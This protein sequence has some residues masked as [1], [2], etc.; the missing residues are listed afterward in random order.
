MGAD[1]A[2]RQT[3]AAPY[4]EGSRDDAEN[5]VNS[6]PLTHLPVDADQ[7]ALLTPN[8]LLKG[9]ATLPN[10]PGLDAELPK[11]GSTRKQWR[12]ARMLRSRFWRRWVLEYLP[13]LVHR[14]KWCRRTD[15]IRQGDT[16]KQWR[17]ARMLRNLFWRRWVL[18]YL[19]TLVHREK[20]CRRKEPIRKGD[21]VFVCDPALLRR[22]W[23]KGIAPL[24]A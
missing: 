22:E 13:T 24:C 14:E 5:V 17:I 12:I 9:A 15:P 4:P 7:E 16:R 2:V 3:S 20:W 8:D 19:P 1:G 6:R 18:E 10:T 23:R 11:E 21:M